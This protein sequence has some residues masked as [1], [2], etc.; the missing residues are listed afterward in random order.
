MAMVIMIIYYILQV[1]VWILF[2]RVI[3]SWFRV[4]PY[5]VWGK[6]YVF[7]FRVTEPF[8]RLIR[9]IIPSLKTGRGYIDFSPIVA[10]L[11]VQVVLWILRFYV[12]RN[13]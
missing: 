13:L 3:L 4:N 11:I 7:L 12:I 1:Y 10:F 8:L 2:A 9:R 5:G 6:L